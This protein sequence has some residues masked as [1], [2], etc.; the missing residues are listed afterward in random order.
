MS[1]RLM[2]KEIF[3]RLPAPKLGPCD[4]SQ[5]RRFARK[6][7]SL[8][9]GLLSPEDLTITQF[10]LLA[11]VERAGQLSH[12]VLAEKGG[13]EP[14]TLPRNLR[15]LT[16]ARWGTAETGQDRGQHLVQ[17][18]AEGGRKLVRC[19]HWWRYA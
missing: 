3:K 7:S 5:G 17:V 19:C 13:M 16:R 15:P 10:S 2:E 8:Y 1:F 4:C 12:A 18:T 14:T 6:L 11:D 9:D